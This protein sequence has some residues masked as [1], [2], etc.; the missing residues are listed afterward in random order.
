MSGGGKFDATLLGVNEGGNS[1][2]V[3]NTELA[4]IRLGMG[5]M[6]TTLCS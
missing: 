1:A 2:R 5:V 3:S 6:A 4:Q